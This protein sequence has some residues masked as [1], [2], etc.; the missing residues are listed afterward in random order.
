M[1]KKLLY[2]KKGASSIMVMLMLVVL[3]VFGIAALTT[4]LSSMRLGQKVVDWNDKYYAA[5]KTANERYAE[6][7]K[8]VRSASGSGD[9]AAAVKSELE[10]LGFGDVQIQGDTLT[11]SYETWSEDIGISAVLA[12]DLSDLTSL[13]PVQW[14]EIQR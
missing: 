11:V 1:I 14:K 3:V 4:A 2:S 8:A 6:A 10:K 13:R 12:L 9:I 7:D 5:E